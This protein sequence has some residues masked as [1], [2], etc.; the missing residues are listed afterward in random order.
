MTPVVIIGGGPAGA[1]MGCYL[2]KAGIKNVLF[3]KAHHPRPHVGESLVT[4]TTR[5]FQEIDFIPVM[6]R[7]GFIRKYGAAW[8]PPANSETINLEFRE[9]PVPDIRQDYTYHVDR[10]RMDL[11]LLEHAASLG[12][13]V[14]QGAWVKEVLFNAEGSSRGVRVELAGR[15]LEVPAAVVVDA[16]GRN[17]LLGGKLGWKRNDPIFKQFAVHAWFEG[18]DRGTGIAA[19]H[20][21][22]HF[23]PVSRGWVW[24]I[25][26]DEWRTSIGVVAEQSVFKQAK[27]DYERWFEKLCGSAPDITRAMR[28]AKRYNDF[29]VEA[30]YSYRMERLCGD[31][32]VL[33][34]DAAR[35]VDPIFSSGV[36]VAL[37]SAKLAAE[38]IVAGLRE[39]DVS[40]RTFEPYEAVIRRGT[41]IW[42]E[43]IKLYYKVVPLFTYFIQ[44]P[45]YRQGVFQLLQG[46]VYDRQEAPVLD[47]MRGYIQSIE[48][49]EGHALRAFLD[50]A[51]PL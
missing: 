24:Q 4:S 50:P 42:Y 27:L 21:H 29:K 45:R 20:I 32:F 5:V 26:I 13:E 46:E 8:H 17:T 37:Y 16:S 6:E 9:F 34:G 12:T 40:R 10:S 51:I 33:I 1:T 2:S 38:R 15:Q 43:F 31:G 11:L 41:D 36:S 47:A 48:Q 18:V 19:D 23:L 39:G 14:H 28:H 49:H 22:I 3:E 44:H 7:A 35:F 30:D 25:P